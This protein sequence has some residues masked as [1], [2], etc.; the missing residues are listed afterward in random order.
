M[1]YNNPGVELPQTGGEGTL[2]LRYLGM[3]V[4]LGAALLLMARQRQ[5]KES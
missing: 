3:T 5:K 4:M 2:H 1:V